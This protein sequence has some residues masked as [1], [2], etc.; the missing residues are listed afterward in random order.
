VPDDERERSSHERLVQLHALAVT[1]ARPSS[2][3]DLVGSRAL[4]EGCRALGASC[5]GLYLTREDGSLEL[6][7]HQG[8]NDAFARATQSLPR[9]ARLPLTWAVRNRAAVWIASPEERAGEWP[10]L[11]ALA[12]ATNN[13]IA[14]CAVVPLIPDREAIGVLA[15]G[16][17]GSRRYDDS[18]RAF[19]G[20]LAQHIAH[21]LQRHD[22]L[23]RERRYADRVRILAEAGELLAGTLDYD[24]TFRN[25]ARIA[26]PSLADFCFFDVLE[27]DGTVHRTPA[28]HDDPETLALLAGTRWAPP[29]QTDVNTCAL[30]SRRVAFHPRI[31][32]AW[33][34]NVA[35]SPEHLDM[36][37]RLVL[38]SMI[39]VPLIDAGDCL[40]ALTVCFGRSKRHHSDADL[41]L[42]QEL[43]RRA[44]AG[45][46]R[47]RLYRTSQ[48]ATRRAERAADEAAKASHLKDDFL[49]T[50]SHEL[51][52]PLSSVLGWATLL[53]ASST[54]AISLSKGLEVIERNARSQQRIIEDILDVSRIVTGKLRLDTEP[55]DL[56]WL[57]ADVLESVRPTADAKGIDLELSSDGSCRLAGD[58]VRLRQVLWNLL[59]NAVKFTDSGGRVTLSLTQMGDRIAVVVEDSGRG[60]DAEFLPHVF[61][62]FRQ[63]DSSTTRQHGGLGLGLAIVRHL[64]EMHG[65]TAHVASDGLGCGSRFS[66]VLPVRPFSSPVAPCA[67]T[68]A[69]D[70]P[71]AAARIRASARLTGLRVLVVEDET[72][73]REL[74]ELLLAGEGATVRT[75]ASAPE[76]LGAAAEFSPDVVLSDVGM[77]ERDGYWLARELRQRWPRLPTIALTAFSSAEDVARALEAGFDRHV[78]KP[79]DPEQLVRAL[80]AQRPDPAGRTTSAA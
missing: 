36:L 49:A 26:M 20:M 16:F 53:R 61:E 6:F 45:V 32:D 80:E 12:T 14:A 43:A 79:V 50:V 5:G 24:A 11:A 54:D 15:F 55:V 70:V 28:A 9:D 72:D 21:A 76:A 60:I 47:A 68:P 78:A 64:A 51:R 67:A 19:V 8:L 52:T 40:G 31:D 29:H 44:G 2:S 7:A 66:L 73:S 22:L 48:E 38:R 27:D 35:A 69:P 25:V 37:R 56:A 57:A 33:M 42:V 4:S 13:G 75:A 46:R 71:L 74:I 77:P 59:S 3:K 1:L 58:A 39:S 23:E 10:E 62:R 63:A 18:D 34:Q 65:G 17:Q 30:S 41:A